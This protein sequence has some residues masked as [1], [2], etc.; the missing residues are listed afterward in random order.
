MPASGR[1]WP[2]PFQVPKNLTRSTCSAPAVS[3]PID[4]RAESGG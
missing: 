4:E 3:M 1:R 2:V